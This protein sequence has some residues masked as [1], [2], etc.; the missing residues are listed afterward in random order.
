MC[1]PVTAAWRPGLI[2][3]GPRPGRQAH[4]NA[5]HSTPCPAAPLGGPSLE[6]ML[7]ILS[8]RHLENLITKTSQIPPFSDPMGENVEL[9]YLVPTL[10]SSLLAASSLLFVLGGQNW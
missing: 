8:L 10:A 1:L 2:L 7:P 5:V 9:T 3:A 4:P 6:P